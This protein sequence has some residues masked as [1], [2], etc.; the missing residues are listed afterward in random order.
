MSAFYQTLRDLFGKAYTNDTVRNEL[1]VTT[2]IEGLANSVERWEVR[3]AKPT[4]FKDAVNL[5]F[6]MLSYL[7]L[8][9]KQPDTS[10]TSDN[11]MNDPLT[12]QSELFSD[13]T[14]SIRG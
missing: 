11:T 14:F 2:F 10:G 1:L 6:E 4:V 3:K 12:F 9:G 8:H 7:N 5:A 13:L